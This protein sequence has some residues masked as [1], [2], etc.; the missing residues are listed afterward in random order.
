MAQ[1]REL[2]AAVL[3]QLDANKTAKPCVAGLNPFLQLGLSRVN[4]KQWA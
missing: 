2:A 1:V 3:R 4:T